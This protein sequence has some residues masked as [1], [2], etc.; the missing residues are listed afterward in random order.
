L[1]TTFVRSLGLENG[2]W[3]EQFVTGH[4]RTQVWAVPPTGGQAAEVHE[5]L[6]GQLHAA[7]EMLHVP[8]NPAFWLQQPD[9]HAGVVQGSPSVS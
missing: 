7:P 4:D 3:I 5:V 6:E 8:A 2:Y 9:W 1:K